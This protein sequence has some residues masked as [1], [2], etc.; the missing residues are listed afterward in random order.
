M[1]YFHISSCMLLKNVLYGILTWFMSHALVY[2]AFHSLH[3]Y[4]SGFWAQF[5][6]ADC[7][8]SF[9]CCT[10]VH[11]A[12]YVGR[13]CALCPMFLLSCSCFNACM[14]L[15]FLVFALSMPAWLCLAPFGNYCPVCLA[16]YQGFY[17]GSFISVPSLV[18]D[19][20]IPC[21]LHWTQVW[22]ASYTLVVF[23][24]CMLCRCLPFWFFLLDPYMHA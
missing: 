5:L 23:P 7:Y 4:L 17:A 24:L 8:A 16:F 14:M 13:R 20:G 19:A 22:L 21:V 12:S 11:C 3:V 15:W 2:T 6:L 18:L 10:Q 9:M 1:C